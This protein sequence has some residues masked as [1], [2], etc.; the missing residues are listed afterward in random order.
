MRNDEQGFLLVIEKWCW[1]IL[2]YCVVDLASEV[3]S[4][5]PL[6]IGQPCPFHAGTYVQL[7]QYSD[8]HSLQL[9]RPGYSR[10]NL[11]G[12]KGEIKWI[13]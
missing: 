12:N 3:P 7:Q 11:V 8:L 4:A 2:Y 5:S 10:G 13:R 1:Q 9:R 6:P